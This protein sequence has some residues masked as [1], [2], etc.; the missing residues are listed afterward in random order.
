MR[1]II[2]D[3]ESVSFTVDIWTSQYTIQSYLGL[4]CHWLAS[5][6]VRRMAVLHCQPF[7]GSHASVN[8][9]KSLDDMLNNWVSTRSG[10]T[11]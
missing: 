8:I 11:L 2:D 6:F 4:T 1:K 10:V 7:S 3:V 9:Q 5:D